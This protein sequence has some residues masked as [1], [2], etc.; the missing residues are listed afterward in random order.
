MLSDASTPAPLPVPPVEE[1]GAVGSSSDILEGSGAGGGNGSVDSFGCIDSGKHMA[2]RGGSSD[3]TTTKMSSRNVRIA[4]E[5]CCHG[6]LDAIYEH[7]ARV[8]S[9]G[10]GPIDLLLIAGDF[11]AV[12]NED[13]LECLAC[14][15]KYRDLRSF[16]EYY[17]GAKVAPVMTIFIGGNHEASNY[18]QELF[19]G[20]WVAPNIYY[21]GRAGVVNF[22]GVRIAGL[23]GIYKPQSYLKGHFERPPYDRGSMRSVYHVREYEICRLKMLRQPVDVFL[24]HDWPLGVYHHGDTDGLLRRKSFLAREV[25]TNTLGSR[26]AGDL[27]R[28]VR[29]RFWFSAHLHVKFAAVVRHGPRAR[30]EERAPGI[31]APKECKRVGIPDPPGPRGSAREST[32]N[33]WGQGSFEN[34]TRFLALDK[35]LPKRDFLQVFDIEAAAG[36]SSD[37]LCYDVE[38]LAILRATHPFM[39]TAQR[40]PPLP[41]P[42]VVDDAVSSALSTMMV[43]TGFN[44]NESLVIPENFVVTVPPHDTSSG[45]KRRRPSQPPQRGN[46]QT[47]ALLS[48]LRLRHSGH[49]IPCSDDGD[50]DGDDDDGEEIILMAPWAPG[51]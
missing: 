25:R 30:E 38:W 19:Y 24:S 4:V 6:E 5:G 50:G 16:H 10:G 27:L 49:T 1:A 40:S 43:E 32:R 47:D 28:S 9:S 45:R 14:P 18:M 44:S 22:R 26:P 11:Q 34:T 31:D 41:P 37:K 36:A 20:G 15:A 39:P 48:M 3:A 2:V 42:H 13:D 51:T 29:P 7:V 8:G 46:P 35:C 33:V 17:S 23:S 21:L 12:R